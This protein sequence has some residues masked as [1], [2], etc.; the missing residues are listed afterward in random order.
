MMVVWS[1]YPRPTSVTDQ[2]GNAC[3]FIQSNY[4]GQCMNVRMENLGTERAGGQFEGFGTAGQ[5]CYSLLNL[6]SSN[7]FAQPYQRDAV[8]RCR[9]VAVGL[10]S[11][12]IIQMSLKALNVLIIPLYHPWQPRK[13]IY[14][15]ASG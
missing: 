15:Y 6:I 11:R 3:S 9:I 5:L 14:F 8:S 12:K 2:W 1:A 4:G 7:H 10:S 13:M